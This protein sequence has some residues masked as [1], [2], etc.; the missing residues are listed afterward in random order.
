MS[1]LFAHVYAACA[2]REEAVQAPLRAELTAGLYGRVLEVGCGHGPNFGYYP[3]EVTEVVAVEPDA[4]LRARAEAAG[5][6]AQVRVR[7]VPGRAETVTGVVDG[8]F[9]AVVFSLVLCSVKDVDLALAQAAALLV[10]GGQLRA[11]EHVA[12]SDPR[13]RRWQRRFAPGW[14]LVAG[15]CRCDRNL[16]GP[17]AARFTITQMRSFRFRAGP[18]ILLALVESRIMVTA[19]LF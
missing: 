1:R 14:A 18:K 19:R 7:V 13:L 10:P 3:P 9:D 8:P 6:L 5:H 17:I 16:L 12:A 15:G 4:Y 2:R 11:Y